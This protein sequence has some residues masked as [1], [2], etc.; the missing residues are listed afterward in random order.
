[1]YMNGYFEHN[2]DILVEAKKYRLEVKMLKDKTNKVKAET[3]EA[4]KKVDDATKRAEDVEAVLERAMN[5]RTSI[6]FFNKKANFISNAYGAGMQFIYEKVAAQYP[7]LNLGFL[8]EFLKLKE[9]EILVDV[10]NEE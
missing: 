9:G 7:G 5:F 8:D 4:E 10:S 1:M 6:K 3:M 2:L